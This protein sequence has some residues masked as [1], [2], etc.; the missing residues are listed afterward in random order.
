[1]VKIRAIHWKKSC[2]L[3]ASLFQ[4][5]SIPPSIM[6][7]IFGLLITVMILFFAACSGSSEET[8]TINDNQETEMVADSVSIEM[9]ELR[10]DIEQ[11]SAELENLL[12]EID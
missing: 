3:N 5:N 9:E 10:E 4:Q 2:I 8:V 6:N 1:M 12:D 7:K 11:T